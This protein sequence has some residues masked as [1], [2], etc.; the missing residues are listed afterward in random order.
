MV[1]LNYGR[2]LI[3]IK[4]L[5]GIHE[6]VDYDLCKGLKLYYNQ[7]AENYP[8][9]WHTALEIVMTFKNDYTVIIGDH[10]HSLQEGD[11]GITPPGTLH[12]LVAPS[13][14][15]RLIMLFDFSFINS[16]FSYQSILHILNPYAL[17]SKASFP[18]LNAELSEYITKIFDEYKNPKPFSE[19]YIYALM[20][21]FF[22]A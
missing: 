17:I 16:T 12:Q 4:K 19:P 3:M 22:V 1:I 9:H 8:L 6:T 7:E 14:G 20:T 5:N 18:E 10:C 21:Q 15:E 2:W 11:I 13:N